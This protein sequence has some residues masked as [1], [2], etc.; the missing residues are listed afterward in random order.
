MV[1]SHKQCSKQN[2]LKICIHR[3][4]FKQERGIIYVLEKSYNDLRMHYRGKKVEKGAIL[5]NGIGSAKLIT[6][7]KF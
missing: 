4:A 2:G 5:P 1:K 7:R 6:K 3:G